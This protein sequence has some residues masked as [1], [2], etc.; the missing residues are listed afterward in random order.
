MYQAWLLTHIGPPKDLGCLYHINQD[1]QLW[2]HT[3]REVQ[4][5]AVPEEQSLCSNAQFLLNY[6]T[7]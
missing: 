1:K 5:L 4:V 6:C 7:T 3:G 2:E